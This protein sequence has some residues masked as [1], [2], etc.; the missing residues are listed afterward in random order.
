MALALA[1]FYYDVLAPHARRIDIWCTDYVHVLASVDEIVEW[2]RGTGLRPWL[3]VLPD[4]VTRRKLERD[5]RA[6][7]APEFPP[8][9]DGRVLFPFRRLFAI[10]YR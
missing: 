3:D 1:D 4:E 8:R 6:R 7:L 10:A 9:A 5:Y 2:Y